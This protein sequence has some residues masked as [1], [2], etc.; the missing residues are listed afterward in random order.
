MTPVA[1]RLGTRF[2]LD[3]VLPTPTLAELNDWYFVMTPYGGC[4]MEI[5]F[6]IAKYLKLFNY[7]KWNLVNLLEYLSNNVLFTS[8]SSDHIKNLIREQL[9]LLINDTS[10]LQAARNKASKIQSSLQDSFKHRIEIKKIF[11]SQDLRFSERRYQINVQLSVMSDKIL[12]AK[13]SNENLSVNKEITKKACSSN[14]EHNL[15]KESHDSLHESP[16][17]LENYGNMQRTEDG[18]ENVEQKEYEDFETEKTICV[19]NIF[20]ETMLSSDA[21]K[22]LTEFFFNHFPGTKIMNLRP[23]SN[24]SLLLDLSLQQDVLHEVF[25]KIDGYIT[26]EIHGYLVKLFNNDL[27]PQGWDNTISN[28]T[29]NINDSDLLS[30]TKRLIKDTFPRFFKAFYLDVL[31][32]LRDLETLEKPHINQ[33]VHPLIDSAL[34]I[35]A[36][37]NYIFGEIPFKNMPTKVRADGIGFLNDVHNYPIVSV[38]G[39]RPGAPE[40]KS[41]DD[42]AKNDIT[43]SILYNNIVILEA[44]ARR[45]LFSDLRQF[46]FSDAHRLFEVDRF[47]LPRDW[48][49]MPNFVF[50]YESLIKWALCVNETKNGLIE[51][52]KK[53]RISRYSEARVVKKLV[54][55]K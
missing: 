16:K 39:A 14:K 48:V 6:Y 3:I 8:E 17:K 23:K 34:W 18:K 21:E 41:F 28:I 12:I 4:L 52:R 25:D 33:F 7:N 46:Q 29:S 42:N 53:R 27:T 54:Q 47:S 45:Y 37:V 30:K 19:K 24:F 22:A 31:N 11:E 38:E 50:L 26:T 51:Q 55:L 2:I 1:C 35:F 32:P 5:E 13:N 20:E 43:M 10:I 40:C 49:E 44:E 15:L 9:D 36:K